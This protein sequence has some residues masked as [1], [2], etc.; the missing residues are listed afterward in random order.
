MV[1]AWALLA[2]LAATVG[3][4]LW[5]WQ[6]GFAAIRNGTDVEYLLLSAGAARLAASIAGVFLLLAA[7][8]AV[9]S[10]L[11][12][13]AAAN[14]R[15]L[16]PRDISYL[17]PAALA[18]FTLLPLLSLAPSLGPAVPPIN[19]L[20]GDLRLGIALLAAALVVRN[21]NQR[22]GG[23]LAGAARHG[24]DRVFGGLSVFRLEIAVAA[25]AIAFAIASS[26]SMRFNSQ[27]HGDETKYIRFAEML[28]QG[29][30]FELSC[31]KD[32]AELPADG[33]P[34]LIKN[35][36]LL[37][38]EA[39]AE[40]GYAAADLRLLL[41]GGKPPGGWNRGTYAPDLMVDGKYGGI[42]QM[43]TPG[44]SFLILPAYV[45]DRYLLSWD[46]GG[47]P[48]FPREHLFTMTFVLLLYGI[49]AGLTF[50]TVLAY[51]GR[52]WMA[53][54][55]A[56]LAAIVIPVGNFP[57]QLY[58]E[59]PAG[60]FIVAIT[61]QL[62]M[63]S[64]SA[65]VSLLL[66]AMAGFLPWFHVRFLL[67]AMIFPAW[68]WLTPRSWRERHLFAL[69]WTLSILTMMA[70]AYH[71]TGSPL[72]TAMYTVRGGEHTPI[73]QNA[74]PGVFGYLYDRAYGV[75][76]YSPIFLLALAGVIPMLRSRFREGSLVLL[77]FGSAA[78]IG[79]LHGYSAAG[80]TAGR[81]LVGVIP[82]AMVP[83]SETISR[84]GDRTSFRVIV[85]ILA[86]L[87]I[88]SAWSYNGHHVKSIGRMLDSSLS[89]WKLH[90]TFPEHIS[91]TSFA[92]PWV[93]SPLLYLWII[94][95]VA[96]VL[97]PLVVR[98]KADTSDGARPGR[99]Y[100]AA[101]AAALAALAAGASL[102]TVT[103]PAA[104]HAEY[105]MEP[106][107]ARRDAVSTFAREGC[108]LCLSSRGGRIDARAWLAP[109]EQGMEVRVVPAAIKIGEGVTLH[110]DGEAPHGWVAWGTLAV[111]FGDG[112]SM[113][114]IRFV[115]AA[116]IVHAYDRPGQFSGTV[117]L[118][119]PAGPVVR[120]FKVL[121]EQ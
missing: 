108:W 107:A 105:M 101:F 78:F 65:A 25:A 1:S 6:S 94:I 37:V 104:I 46:A 72:P 120:G 57:F 109:P 89:G 7:V 27:L 111:N 51:A 30:G 85:T 41:R 32:I 21:V 59:I 91:G 43:H 11:L 10:R 47:H 84:F 56:V 112:D 52:P 93:R 63:P 9:C 76:P 71:L 96:S 68:V 20:F 42:Y 48:N 67:T 39:K 61:W 40:A 4:A 24:R 83:L 82:L 2:V 18:G 8:H 3:T 113:T 5:F 49:L 98:Q 69:G 70:Y 77:A 119:T 114:D 75:L 31:R 28:Y 15:A 117:T 115:D 110:I 23:R 92:E 62:L 103:R 35:L 118:H 22:S 36:S 88:E 66:G 12:F 38:R 74:P 79:S 86:G 19:Y 73:L 16:R 58:P 100:G 50:R 64:R 44:T 80:A 34:R 13:R 116:R 55:L 26:P 14:W 95:T 45:L 29:C 99:R 81:Y 121:V 97:I 87:S 106:A 60:V 17:T 33:S 90:L 53:A 102:V 54:G